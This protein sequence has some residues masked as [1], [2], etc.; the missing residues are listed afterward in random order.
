MRA[1]AK[2]R[3]PFFCDLPVRASSQ[4]PRRWCGSHV[5]FLDCANV[6]TAV[7]AGA[8]RMLPTFAHAFVF[9]TKSPRITIGH[10][11]AAVVMSN[12]AMVSSNAKFDENC[13]F[14]MTF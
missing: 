13:A 9:W 2:F 3:S 5:A 1:E 6:S 8:G 14:V 11:S 10:F 12:R 7:F 4:Y